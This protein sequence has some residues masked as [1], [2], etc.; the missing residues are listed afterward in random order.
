MKKL[1]YLVL[2]LA[3]VF[4]TS[5]VFAAA[6]NASRTRYG[7]ASTPNI[8]DASA[9]NTADVT[10]AGDL[11]VRPRTKQEVTISSKVV[12]VS[13][14]MVSTAATLHSVTFTAGKAGDLIG[15]YDSNPEQNGNPLFEIEVGTA[16]QTIFLPFPGGVPFG[17]EIEVKFFGALGDDWVTITYDTDTI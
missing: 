8:T 10:A 3:L 15:I 1:T 14:R 16:N 12:G 5:D 4:T 13:Q 17:T 6:T 11:I 2:A 9:G 7:S